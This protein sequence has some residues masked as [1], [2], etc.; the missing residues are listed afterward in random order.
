LNNSGELVAEMLT[1]LQAGTRNASPAVSATDQNENSCSVRKAMAKAFG[2]GRE[3][4]RSEKVGG[5]ESTRL[6]SARVNRQLP[7]STPRYCLP[8]ATMRSVGAFSGSV[9][10]G[11]G[12]RFAF[13]G[14]TP[15]CRSNRSANRSRNRCGR[16]L[17]P[18][19]TLPRRRRPTLPA[20]SGALAFSAAALIQ[21]RHH[22][23]VKVCFTNSSRRRKSGAA[24]T[25]P[26]KPE[27]GP[28]RCS[29]EWRS[30]P[31]SRSDRNI[32]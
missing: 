11:S 13:S 14:D 26:L 25:S 24:C 17:L 12:T 5:R 20:V 19:R 10:D 2:Q 16:G 22:S 27:V 30:S 18:V 3:N 4:G 6:R 8:Y 23:S 9:G 29:S 21:R 1:I 28:C 7:R 32:G 15:R 31:P